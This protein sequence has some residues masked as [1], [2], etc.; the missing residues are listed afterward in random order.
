MKKTNYKNT[1]VFFFSRIYKKFPQYYLIIFLYSLFNAMLYLLN[2]T[3]PP[4]LIGAVLN[5]NFTQIAFVVFL[6]LSVK[7]ITEFLLHIAGCLKNNITVRIDQYFNR[8]FRMNI[9]NAP[10]GFIEQASNQN[11]IEYAGN[12]YKYYANGIEGL[13]NNLSALVSNI[14]IIAGVFGIVGKYSM[15]LAAIIPFVFLYV[16]LQNKINKNTEKAR[17]NISKYNRSR[18][19]MYYEITELKFGMDIRLFDASDKF[20]SKVKDFNN[21]LIGIDLGLIQC[22]NKYMLAKNI[23]SDLIN[24]AYYIFAS[25][26]LFVRKV[27]VPIFTALISSFDQFQSSVSEC[28]YNIQELRFRIK[29][30]NEYVMLRNKLLEQNTSEQGEIEVTS[31]ET[32]KFNNVY[33]KYPGTDKNILENFNIKINKGEKLAVVGLNG[34]GKTTFI[35]LLT[36]LYYSDSGNLL[37]NGSDIKDLS[38]KSYLNR[39]TAVFQDF[40]IFAFSVRDNL[41]LDDPNNVSDTKIDEALEL[42]GLKNVICSLRNGSDT[43]LSKQYA[44]DGT[45]LSGGEQ[46]KIAIARAWLRNADVIILDEPTAALD[47]IAEYEVYNHFNTITEGKTTIYVSHRLSACKFADKIAVIDN[48]SVSEYG[49]HN[50]LVKLGGIYANMYRA[51]AQYYT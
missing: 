47:P 22:N 31:I 18:N 33:F 41:L 37:I 24:G 16:H 43:A 35:K 15:I 8:S 40:Q 23:L 7:L 3:F 38:R 4:L 19:Y 36:S 2:V 5:K 6:F 45:E 13:F 50:E 32:I 1:V 10:F 51:Q 29:Y 49:T 21:M 30:L 46:Q 26:L 39:L 44:D 20:L 17:G 9:M 48:G 12:C 28:I 34:S 42:L 11:E 14:L 25:V 27:N